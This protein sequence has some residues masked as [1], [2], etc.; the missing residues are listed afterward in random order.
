MKWYDLQGIQID[1]PQGVTFR[2]VADPSNL[3]EWT[4]AFATVD[5]AK[6][7]MRTPNGEISVELVTRA[8]ETR[9]TVDWKMTFPDGS[10]GWAYSR[11][12]PLDGRR[13]LYAFALT[14]PP[15]PLEE[16]EG[17]LVEQ[18]RALTEELR[19]LKRIVEHG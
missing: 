5:G 19:N 17:T 15:V 9:G 11:V 14:P 8:D 10:S 13:C 1:R 4:H 6:A 18:S 12:L 16:V 7:R 2:Y 3:P